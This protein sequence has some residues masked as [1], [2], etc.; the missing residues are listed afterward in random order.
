MSMPRTKKAFDPARGIYKNCG[1]YWL[2]YQKDKKRSFVS[3]ETHDFA[4]AVQ[5]ATEVRKSP[6]IN[7]GHFMGEM[8][9]RFIAYKVRHGEY[10]RFSAQNK[11]GVLRSF[12]KFIGEV[13]PFQIS[14]AQV[15]AFY[16][17][18]RG[19]VTE[20]TVH[21]YL[22]AIRSFF[23]WCLTVE[24]TV[25]SNPCLNVRTGKTVSASRKKFCEPALRDRLIDK[26][27]RQD[28]KFV[29]YCGFHAG[30]RRNEITEARPEW[31]DMKR[32]MVHI[33]KLTPKMAE[34]LGLD[35]FD[36]K[37]REERSI[38]L[39]SE[40]EAFLKT[41]PMDGAYCIAPDKRR[42]VNRYRYEFH[43]PFVGYM[44]EQS[45]PWV[46]IHT[47]RHT[48]ASLLASEGVSIALISN[49]LGDDIRTTTRHYAH[50]LPKHDEIEK[51]FKR[52]EKV[53]T[54][55][56]AKKKQKSRRKSVSLAAVLAG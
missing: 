1:V 24:K 33:T 38:P 17:S 25:R 18:H 11:E 45:C 31:F 12:A 56:P 5:R 15:Q 44:E 50:F 14:T 9:D 3:L 47:M 36:V 34:S 13:A 41:Y 40:F 7:K 20:S 8:I 23:Q 54:T 51:A 2:A 35:P 10:S 48:F 30:M 55:K 28:L 29:L 21:A 6:E 22:M 16:D 52:P 49:W 19:R 4:T 32:R 46:T 37:D 27:K 26:C 53:Q 42:Q 43:R 39:T